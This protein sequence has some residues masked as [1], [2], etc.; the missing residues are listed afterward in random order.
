MK[1]MKFISLNC[2]QLLI[3]NTLSKVGNLKTSS[4]NIN[5]DSQQGNISTFMLI[6]H[7]LVFLINFWTDQLFK[8]V[9]QTYSIKKW[10]I[11]T[12]SFPFYFEI[13][14]KFFYIPQHGQTLG[15]NN[16]TNA[17]FTLRW[18]AFCNQTLLTNSIWYLIKELISWSECFWKRLAF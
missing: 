8:S 6:L 15:P 14:T 11:N 10:P 18:L 17:V 5:E 3:S 1:L 12:S 16:Q 9:L 7:S 2:L 4:S 13:F